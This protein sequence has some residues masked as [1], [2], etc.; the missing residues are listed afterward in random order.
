VPQNAFDKRAHMTG[1]PFSVTRYLL[2]S[3]G[4]TFASGITRGPARHIITVS[5]IVACMN[6]P[7]M[8][9]V[10]PVLPSLASI[11]HDRNIDLVFMV[12]KLVF[13]LVLC[14]LCFLLGKPENV[15]FSRE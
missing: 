9:Q 4:S 8:S 1:F 15:S 7:G 6:T 3:F 11:A 13:S 5:S 14:V 12:G 2:C 10:M